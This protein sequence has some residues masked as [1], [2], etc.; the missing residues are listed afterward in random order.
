MK[1]RGGRVWRE[2]E[3]TLQVYAL[4][5]HSQYRMSSEAPSFRLRSEHP[6]QS[7]NN[8][9]LHN[10][11]L[12]ARLEQ[13]T[14]RANRS[15]LQQLPRL[16]ESI[17]RVTNVVTAARLVTEVVTETVGV[18]ERE[19]GRET[20]VR[21]LALPPL[22]SPPTPALPLPHTPTLPLTLTA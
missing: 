13:L 9:V 14:A 11:V 12:H 20:R 15:C 16:R 21:T 10:T 18:R 17:C 1:A 4:Q 5:L 22:S 2:A 8:T 19:V 6:D 3:L 7:S